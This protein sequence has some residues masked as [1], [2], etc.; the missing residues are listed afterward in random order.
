MESHFRANVLNR[1]CSRK[2][3]LHNWCQWP[4]VSFS[5]EQTFFWIAMVKL[6]WTEIFEILE[7]KLSLS[8]ST[9]HYFSF[10]LVILKLHVD[11]PCPGSCVWCRDTMPSFN[12]EWEIS[13]YSSPWLPA[14]GT[15]RTQLY[16]SSPV[17]PVCQKKKKKKICSLYCR[18]LFSR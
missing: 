10:L 13:V 5:L 1:E 16:Y 18:I 3:A 17:P 14:K 8:M 2:K 15:T 11:G 12:R 9:V 6:G 7:K 4:V